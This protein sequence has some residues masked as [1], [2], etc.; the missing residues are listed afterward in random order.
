[1]EEVPQEIR[2]KISKTLKGH[3]VS[4]ETRRKMSEAQ[5]RRFEQEGEREKASERS[6]RA[7]ADPSS[8]LNS[9]EYRAGLRRSPSEEVRQKRAE[10]LKE[11]WT[12]PE[13]RAKMLE[14][15]QDPEVRER[16]REQQLEYWTE[17]KKL[18]QRLKLRTSGET[19]YVGSQGYRTLRY[20]YEHP[21]ADSV[22][23]ELLE[24]RKVLWE[25]LGCESVDC[26]HGCHWNCGRVLTWGGR[27][28]IHVDH[29]DE[30]KLNNDPE[31]L[32]VSCFACN[33][34]RGW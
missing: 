18:E 5:K 24:H 22:S 33:I 6:K 28:G 7:W 30:D 20:E 4:E 8:K 14:I 17:E 23:G 15:H 25:K 11:K 13:F 19:S 3:S 34:R 2:D 21:L 27:E 29:L 31:N 1:M 26:E 32:V 12:D 16:K 9:E 10:S